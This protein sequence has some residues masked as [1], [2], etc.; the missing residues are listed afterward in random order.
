MCPCGTPSALRSQRT[1]AKSLGLYFSYSD[2]EK[3]FTGEDR[4]SAIIEWQEPHL[5]IITFKDFG[6]IWDEKPRPPLSFSLLALP[7]P[8]HPA[9]RLYQGPYSQLR[10]SVGRR[11]DDPRWA[12]GGPWLT[13]LWNAFPNES[14]RAGLFPLWP[15]TCHQTG[16]HYRIRRSW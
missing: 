15:Y 11:G 3:S 14:Q 8:L 12:Q 2:R 4:F 16:M 10:Y 1:Y 9:W 7:Q 13:P 6:G 5:E